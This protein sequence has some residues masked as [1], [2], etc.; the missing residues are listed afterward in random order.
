MHKG[1]TRR[2][3]LRDSIVLGTGVAASVAGLESILPAVSEAKKKPI[4][5][6]QPGGDKVK[7]PENGCYVGFLHP[8]AFEGFTFEAVN[9]WPDRNKLHRSENI[10]DFLSANEETEEGGVAYTI[11]RL[12]REVGKRPAILLLHSDGFDLSTGFR[13]ENAEAAASLGVI[14]LIYLDISPYSL[15]DIVKNNVQNGQTTEDAL[16]RYF[17]GAA[18]HG[19]KHGGFFM[20]PLWE[21]NVPSKYHWWREHWGGDSS[22]TK[23]AWDI[24]WNISEKEGANTW[25]TWMPVIYPDFNYKSFIPDNKQIDWIGFSGYDR[26]QYRQ[27]YGARNI[28]RIFNG[29]IRGLS[30]LG[31]P[32]AF[33]EFGTTKERS[34]PRWVKKAYSK[35]LPKMP[36]IKAACYSNTQESSNSDIR[37]S[38]ESKAVLKEILKSGYWIG[39]RT[40]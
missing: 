23:A 24:M 13:K 15:K 21:M 29:V 4:V 18:E 16:K 14:P 31:K 6:Q 1:Y 26:K 34:Q 38:E 5:I 27:H 19:S 2:E 12:E 37:L 3:F 36:W 7:Y 32:M 25:A 8:Y 33:A 11:G 35:Y 20:S 22:R 9:A 28:N 39:T 40:T 10:R 30:K 17:A